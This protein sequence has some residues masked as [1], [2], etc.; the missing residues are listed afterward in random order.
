MKRK[1]RAPVEV[2]AKDGASPAVIALSRYEFESLRTGKEFNLYRGRG[3]GEVSPILVRAPSSERPEPATLKQLEHEY[4]LRNDLDPEWAARPLELGQ[5]EGR[6][7][8][9]LEDPDPAA[10]GLDRFVGEPMELSRFL[11]LAINLA[12]GLGKLHRRGLIHKDIKP[13]KILVNLTTHQAWFTGF[14]IASRLPRERQAL[15][16][17]ELIA[18]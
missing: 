12:A 4:S 13:S 17:P 6:T 11:N 7:V 1:D 9:I 8:L 5:L 18:G 14:G 3:G 2:S 15:E 16:A 10:A